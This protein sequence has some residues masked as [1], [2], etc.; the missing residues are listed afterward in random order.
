MLCAEP[1]RQQPADGNDGDYQAMKHIIAS[2]L[3]LL[4]LAA[5]SVRAQNEL[6]ANPK[7]VKLRRVWTLQGRDGYAD[8]VGSAV[9]AL[10]DID[11]D[12]S[13]AIAVRDRFAIRFYHA[14]N[15]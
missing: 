6:V 3:A 7:A 15:P 4:L 11:G 8:E 9:G 2:T 13:T 5:A 10:F 1:L 12:G 14:G